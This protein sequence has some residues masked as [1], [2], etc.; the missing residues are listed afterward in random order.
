MHDGNELCLELGL[1]IMDDVLD[2]GGDGVP[3]GERGV[4]NDA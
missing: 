3:G 2:G 4:H 1:Y